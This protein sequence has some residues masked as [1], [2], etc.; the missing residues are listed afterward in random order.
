[1]SSLW[2]LSRDEALRN[3]LDR[4][5]G[6]ADTRLGSPTDAAEAGWGAEA[7]P[8]VVVLCV[9]GD[10]EAE[11]QFAYRVSR[12]APETRWLL[13]AASDDLSEVEQ[14]FDAL[15]AE[16]LAWDGDA[17]LVRAR[18]H[19]LRSRR[20]SPPLSERGRRE[21][22]TERFA[23]AMADLELPALFLAS[24]PKRVEIPLLIRG[25]AGSG[26][27]LLARY[28]HQLGTGVPAGPFIS[29]PCP[30][31]R[32]LTSLEAS[33]VLETGQL[34][35][36]QLVTVCFEEVDR[37]PEALQ[38][39][40]AGWVEHGPPGLVRAGRL[41]WMATS[42]GGTLAPELERVI[43]E[44]ELALPPLRDTADRIPA[45]ARRIARTWARRRGLP[46]R[47]FSAEALDALA[48]Q[49][50]PGN[51]RELEGVIARTLARSGASP[52]G[53]DDFALEHAAPAP[54]AGANANRQAGRPEADQLPE[55][56][57]AGEA[58]ELLDA[59]LE[60]VAEP[61]PRFPATAAGS[62]RRLAGAVA[63][64]LGNPLVG[65]RSFAQ[66]LPRRFDNAEFR[67]QAPERVAN[68]TRSV[69]AV[70]ETLTR[71]G[72]LRPPEAIEVDLT[73]LL[74]GLLAERRQRLDERH[75]VV[76][77]EL[78]R[79]G[80]RVLADR[81]QLRFGLATF[82][83]A[84]LELIPE[85]GDLYVATRRHGGDDERRAQVR[86]L[87]RFSTGE[88]PPSGEGGLSRVEQ[89]LGIVALETVV[90]AQG[91]HFALDLAELP[92]ALI[93]FE[94]AAA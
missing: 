17:T 26:R 38:R 12:R 92:A 68:D 21:R 89:S 7:A 10:F 51:L 9:A 62:L 56:E 28:L 94:L 67:S 69:E 93:L 11:L 80:G 33:W 36:A 74:A 76:L 52:I 29:L 39:V 4:Q 43:A 41:R 50:W 15:A 84:L 19:A 49:A 22:L 75:L 71:L 27:G 34:P 42:D 35:S 86:T 64:E 1:M 54:L 72:S 73:S 5:L 77:E 44:I 23:D 79:E 48:R 66:M 87:I 24:D 45:L 91:G 20:S 53:V 13:V 60:V 61:E 3:E 82:F 58:D 83:D 59:E 32:D 70:L 25:E 8:P 14:L 30:A 88:A 31:V 78:D 55:A 85:R 63:H 40:V 6:I 16:C 65:I 37:L 2:I 18:V 90:G 46:E 81:E 57:L 47:E